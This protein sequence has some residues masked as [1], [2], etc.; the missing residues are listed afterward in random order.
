MAAE[1]IQRQ[2]DRLLDEAEEALS[3]RDWESVRDCARD[4][5]ALARIHRRRAS[6]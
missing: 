2:V 3:R 6:G 4:V 5:L 1:R